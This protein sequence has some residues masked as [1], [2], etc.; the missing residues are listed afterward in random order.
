M[1][2]PSSGQIALS[3]VNVELGY[4]S[5]QYITLN[6]TLV[7]NLAARPT[8]GSIISM[9][10]DFW[11][12]SA[13]TTTYS[14]TS[15][16]PNVNEGSSVTF[17]IGGT[18]ITNGT[19]YWTVS[20]FGDFGVAGGSVVVTNNSGSFSVTPTADNLTEGA[21]TFY[22][23]LKSGSTSG[24][25][26]ATSNVVTINDTSQTPGSSYTIYPSVSSVNE[27]G[28]VTFTVGGSNITNGTYYWTVTNAGDFNTSSGSFSINSNSGS[29]SV[30]ATA[31]LTTEGNESFTASV[32]SGS[33]SGPVLVTSSS[34]LINDTSQTPPPATYT[35]SPSASNVNEG[36]TLTFNVGGT[37]IANGT[38]Y[39]TVT[40]AGDFN[41]S[42][43]SFSI[44][45]NSGSFSVTPNSDLT[46]EGNESFT[47]SV[48]SGSISGPVLVTSSNITINDTS[49]NP[50]VFT[51]YP[52]LGIP[53][54]SVVPA[55]NARTSLSNTN[56]FGIRNRLTFIKQTTNVRG[57][58]RQSTS[59]FNQN[60][61]GTF[62][63]VGGT[64]YGIGPLPS[65][66]AGF[67]KFTLLSTSGTISNNTTP[68]A[69]TQITTTGPEISVNRPGVNNPA[70][71]G[72]SEATF[73]IDYSPTGSDG[74]ITATTT[75]IMR[76]TI[77]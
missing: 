13:V 47:A 64:P 25:I 1:T 15:S 45:S 44:N 70:S 48:R 10:S 5:T 37:N 35:I 6:D 27:G 66:P 33:I 24:P 60:F 3:N 63:P 51:P 61:S 73:R 59:I 72:T 32:R 75:V 8:A 21:E 34:V 23:F 76:M 26:L 54:N 42:F 22:A 57:T 31:D 7:R 28:T 16:S 17:T 67:L 19:Y 39:W 41:T 77:T 46:T 12:K 11:G 30:T 56:S 62:T 2:L 68:T 20:N 9:P 18:Q 40:N 14:L 50:T 36:S 49:G 53:P 69:W 65:S 29:F 55:S 4:G 58:F 71:V 74:N 52:N 38:Y 43:G